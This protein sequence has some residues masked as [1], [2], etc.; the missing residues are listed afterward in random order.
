MELLDKFTSID[1]TPIIISGRGN[2]NGCQAIKNG[3]SEFEKPF[4]I[5][6]LLL[7]VEDQLNEVK[8]ENKYLKTS[9]YDY[10]FMETLPNIKN[11][12]SINI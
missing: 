1:A 10:E 6:R 4:N 5:E 2:I 7:S 3:A 11:Q 9:R 12:N 8:N